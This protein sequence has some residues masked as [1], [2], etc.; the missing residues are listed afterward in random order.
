MSE[1]E[2]RHEV[3]YANSAASEKSSSMLLNL[4]RQKI[5]PEI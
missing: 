3:M 1:G 5:E 4:R 2:D